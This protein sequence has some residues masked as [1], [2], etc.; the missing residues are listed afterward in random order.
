MLS[1]R[2]AGFTLIE[3][4]LAMTLLS[5]M[6]VLLFSSLATGAES[7]NRGEHKIAEINKKAVAYQFFQRHLPSIRPL[8][9]NFSDDE[10]HFSFQGDK[11]SLK[12]VSVFPSSAS[13]KGLQIFKIVFNKQDQQSIS[14]KIMPFFPTTKDGQWQEEEVVLVDDVEALKLSYFGVDKGTEEP[15]WLDQW[16]DK[17]SLPLLVKINI[18]L[19]DESYWPEM[20][21]ALKLAKKSPEREHGGFE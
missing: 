13:R 5:I 21:F 14:V 15:N 4:L 2:N 19:R 7:W 6:M 10:R 12:F 3:V 11:E 8:W 9:D 1:K 20:I 16:Q 17:N 18:M